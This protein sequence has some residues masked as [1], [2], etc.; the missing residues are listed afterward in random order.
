MYHR[1]TWTLRERSTPSTPVKFEEHTPSMEPGTQLPAPF[2][3]GADL[4]TQ[5]RLIGEV[6]RR[7]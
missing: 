3:L 2:D 4:P 6:Y 7:A 1:D 5:L